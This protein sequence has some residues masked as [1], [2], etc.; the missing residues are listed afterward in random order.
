MILA[1]DIT[2]T[3]GT[4]A[5]NRSQVLKDVS[6][7]VGEATVCS[8]LGPSGSG[9]ST[10]LQCISGLETVDS[11]AS[12][13]AGRDV[14]SLTSRQSEQFRRDD[15]GFVFQEHNL[16]ADLTLSENITLDRP[17]IPDVAELLRKWDIESVAGQFPAQCS[18]GQ[19]QKAAILRALNKRA[20]VL[21][22]DEPTGSLDTAS[23]RYV[24]ATL[25]GLTTT[26]GV[27]VLMIS[28]NE[29]VTQI[30]DHVV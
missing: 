28:H 8:V 10:L 4:H 22:C 19:Q 29:L 20:P 3:Y 14:H 30:S 6:L 18:G 23:A 15:I 25:Q 16:I 5:Q 24:F 27:T 21:F 2:K 7:R 26:F 9:K 1:K 13:V 17:M 12:T 11:G